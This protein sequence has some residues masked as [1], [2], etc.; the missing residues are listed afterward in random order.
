MRNIRVPIPPL[1][2]RKRFVENSRLEYRQ[3]LDLQEQAQAQHERFENSLGGEMR[4]WGTDGSASSDNKFEMDE[5][6]IV[7]RL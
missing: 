6:R 5:R 7:R 3:Y 4:R 2:E 1:E